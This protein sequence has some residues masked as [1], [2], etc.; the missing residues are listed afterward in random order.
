[1]AVEAT[2]TVDHTV[3]RR[4]VFRRFRTA[5]PPIRS[6]KRILRFCPLQ[7]S[8]TDGDQVA[9]GRPLRGR[10]HMPAVLHAPWPRVDLP[11]SVLPSFKPESPN[12]LKCQQIIATFCRWGGRR[13]AKHAPMFSVGC[14]PCSTE[15][16]PVANCIKSPTF[17]GYESPRHLIH[18][19]YPAVVGKSS[20]T[21]KLLYST[22]QSSSY[23][24]QVGA[25]IG[26]LAIVDRRMT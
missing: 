17:C 15:V 21:S 7:E 22:P 1:M 4:T 3:P 8:K 25:T 14:G 24:P 18:R 11:A 16:F 12:H 6:P 2:A 19:Q 20:S 23:E 13:G 26:N 9:L 10:L 5:V